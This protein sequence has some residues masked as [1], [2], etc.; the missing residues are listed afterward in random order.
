MPPQWQGMVQFS[1]RAYIHR[2]PFQWK[3]KVWGQIKLSKVCSQI[4][5]LSF[6]VIYLFICVKATSLD[7]MHDVGDTWCSASS[8]WC[9]VSSTSFFTSLNK[10]LSTVGF[11]P[12]FASVGA[13]DCK[14][15]PGAVQVSGRSPL[16]LTR[17]RLS[18]SSSI[19]TASFSAWWK[20][21]G[22]GP[23]TRRT[24]QDAPARASGALNYGRERQKMLRAHAQTGSFVTSK[25]IYIL[26]GKSSYYLTNHKHMWLILVYYIL[27]NTLVCCFRI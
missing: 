27:V 4:F 5:F 17:P 3:S 11:C 9:C 6:Y 24:A 10:S 22:C 1:T 18:A 13:C 16:T 2:H 23:V 8:S 20:M 7:L 14:S 19:F 21:G 26:P 15:S 12:M 25:K